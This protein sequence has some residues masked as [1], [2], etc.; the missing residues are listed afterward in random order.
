M[1]VFIAR[2]ILSDKGIPWKNKCG[3]GHRKLRVCVVKNPDRI[4]AYITF[5][6]LFQLPRAKEIVFFAAGIQLYTLA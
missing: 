6:N 1:L 3:S 5:P 4:G 2:G